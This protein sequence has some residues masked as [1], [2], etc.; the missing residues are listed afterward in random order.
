MRARH[1]TSRMLSSRRTFLQ[2][3]G[4]AAVAAG[5][6]RATAQ[7]A[8]F[9]H[10]KHKDILGPD[11]EKI[12]LRGI[13]LGNWLVQEGYM[14]LFEGG[15]ES[16]REIEAYFDQLLGPEAARDFWIEYRRNYIAKADID[17]IASCGLNSVRIPLHYKFFVDDAG[18]AL[19]DPVIGWCRAAGLWVI[20][21]MHCAPGGQTGANIDDSWGYPWLFESAASQE[22]T[23]EVW[24]R[25][26]RHYR[27]E[28]AVLGYDLLNE[29]IPNVPAIEKYNAQLEPL[30]RRIGDAIRQV[31]TNHALI[32]EGAQWANNLGVFG[33][34][35]DPNC[36]YEFH[37]YWTDVNDDMINHYLDFRDDRNAPIWLGESGENTD[38][39]VA[40]FIRVLEHNH[41]GWCFWPYKKMGKPSCMVSV[42]TPAHWEEIAAFARVAQNTGNPA[43]R[44]GARP[45]Q[46]R[47]QAATAELLENVRFERCR[48][49]PGYLN[50]LGTSPGGASG[51]RR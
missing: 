37:L 42:Q 31:D 32:L 13:S 43:G 15:P 2:T 12:R 30:Y 38:E 44:I 7:A 26:A 8:G 48:P 49:N 23:I 33:K 4:A 36:I 51:Q 5:A 21:D 50:A 18:F 24:T 20:L 9:V 47:I 14:F 27:D 29:P 10:T 25:I 1:Y 17:Y 46:E 39:W 3:V 45:P 34:P 16:P 22:Q 28:S 41:V 19:L 11:G 35:F 6:G 40:G